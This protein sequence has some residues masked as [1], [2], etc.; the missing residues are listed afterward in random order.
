MRTFSVFPKRDIGG[1]MVRCSVDDA[2]QFELWEQCLGS[3]CY[4]ATVPTWAIAQELID[5]L[6]ASVRIDVYGGVAHYVVTRGSVEI[7]F[8]DHDDC[9]VN[10]N[11]GIPALVC[12]QCRADRKGESNAT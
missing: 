12:E 6:N 5:A 11:N 8:C 7:V 3:Q 10:I 2:E 4:Y 9:E 1:E